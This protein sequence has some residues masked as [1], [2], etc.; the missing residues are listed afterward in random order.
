MS[1]LIKNSNIIFKQYL[2][3]YSK[4]SYEIYDVEKFSAS[5]RYS[6]GDRNAVEEPDLI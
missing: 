3:Q 2:K 6:N 5:L 4:L 1:I